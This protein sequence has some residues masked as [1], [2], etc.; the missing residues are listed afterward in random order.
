[1]G[2]WSLEG[3]RWNLTWRR[4]WIQWEIQ[5]VN[6]L[7]D[8]IGVHG[9]KKDM[10]DGWVWKLNGGSEYVT[11]EVYEALDGEGGDVDEEL[12]KQLWKLL[13]EIELNE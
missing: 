12:Y 2:V 9:L 3:W 10:S 5:L 8:I 1:M 13:T 4:P 7:W 6:K 11:S